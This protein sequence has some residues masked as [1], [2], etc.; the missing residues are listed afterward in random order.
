M[1]VEQAVPSA[2]SH[3]DAADLLDALS[4]GIVML[5]AQLCA[6]YANVAA[7]DLLAFSL[8]HGARP[9]LQRLPARC[10]KASRRS[11]G[12]RSRR[13]ESLADRELALRPAGAPREARTLD[14]TITPFAGRHRHAPVA[15]DRGH[16]ATA[17]HLARER[18]AGAARRQ[19]PDGP[20]ARRTRSKTPSGGLRG[21]AQLLER[22][23]PV[24]GTE[25]IHAAHHRRSRPPDRARR[26]DVGAH[27]A[28]PPRPRSTCT[29]SASTCTTCC[30]R[31][32]PPASASSAT[33]TRAC[34]T[35]C[36]TGTRSSR[37]C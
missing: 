9:S 11:C 23:L 13:G 35:R 16:H 14:V 2:L 26:L 36:S 31:K 33:T 8:K 37:R 29:R 32:P 24:A 6:V 12:A 25:G 34:R 10:A 17:A 7:Q 4:T 19:P 21:A 30:A 22:E 1:A 5:D 3:F 27:A 28:R 20:P 18:P 15:R